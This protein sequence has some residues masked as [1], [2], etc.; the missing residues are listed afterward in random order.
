[1]TVIPSQALPGSGPGVRSEA[2]GPR[3][4]DAAVPAAIDGP[5]TSD[6]GALFPAL[7][8][9]AE[10]TRSPESSV[11]PLPTPS[12]EPSPSAVTLRDL[13]EQN[14]AVQDALENDGRW[15]GR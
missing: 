11:S 8:I 15:G 12:V 1:M 2:Q 9:L 6:D 7:E 3:A 4:S 5:L 13:L 10:P 14:P